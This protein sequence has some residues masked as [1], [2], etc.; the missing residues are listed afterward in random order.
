MQC[1]LTQKCPIPLLLVVTRFG[2]IMGVD[3]G[4]AYAAFA[5]GVGYAVGAFGIEAVREESVVVGVVGREAQFGQIG[6]WRWLLQA[7]GFGCAVNIKEDEGGLSGT[8]DG[9]AGDVVV[10]GGERDHFA[11]VG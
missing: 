6:V 8:E 7:K 1:D 2:M 5:T 11:A 4:F 10:L 3:V 9:E